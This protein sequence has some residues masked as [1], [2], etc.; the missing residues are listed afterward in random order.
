MNSTDITLQQILL[1]TK[2]KP[3]PQGAG[4]KGHCPAHKDKSPSLSIDQAADGTILLTCHA[5]CSNKAVCVGLN[6]TQADLFPPKLTQGNQA[7]PKYNLD[8]VY[9]YKDESGNLLF[10]AVRRRLANA[11][12]CPNASPKDFKQRQPD[13]N[14]GWIWNLKGVRR[15][16]YRLTELIAAIAANPDITVFIVEGEKD[17]D[18]LRSL[19]LTAT[20]N[21]GGAG[22]WRDEYSDFLVGREVVILP[23]ND[24]AGQNHAQAVA[25]SLHGKAKKIQILDLPKLNP[26]GD[27]SDW[28]DGGGDEDQLCQMSLAAP[29]WTPT[30]QGQQPNPPAQPA[31]KRKIDP[32]DLAQN[33][34]DFFHDP[35]GRQYAS[36]KINAHIETR[37]VDSKGF[38]LWLRG[39]FFKDTGAPL[40]GELLAETVATLQ[41]IAQF[42]SGEKRVHLRV[43]EHGGNIYVDLCDA[44]WRVVEITPNGYQVI[45]PT[46]APVVFTRRGGMSALPEPV[47]GGALA[48]LRDFINCAE[49]QDDYSWALIAGWL[50]MCFHPRG[51][52]PILSIGGEQGSGKSTSCRML[53]RLIDPNAGD[54][55]GVPKDERD[56]M[57]AAN[58]CWLLGYDNLSGATQETSDRLC[59]IST[60]A[61]FGTRTLHTNDEETIFAAR[62]P[63]LVNGIADIHYPDFLDR[64]VSVYLRRI[65]DDQRRDEKTIWAEFMNDKPRILGAL[66]SGVSHALK[67]HQSVKLDHKPRM[68]DFAIWASAAEEGMGLAGGAFITAYEGNREAAH[69]VALDTS[70][71][72]EIR[73]FVESLTDP[74]WQGRAKELLDALNLML[75]GKGIDPLTKW[76][77]PKAANKLT[78]ALRRIG[79]N[80]R[81]VGIEVNCDRS[82]KGSKITIKRTK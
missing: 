21:P 50:V 31:T 10:Q 30:P 17:V 42:Q 6:I 40:H 72:I 75:K 32:I 15:V 63:I 34:A 26:K 37:P 44:Q 71:A 66:L 18:K 9:D 19:G 81:S 55:R 49:P 41:S 1:K 24:Q 77:W 54:L 65:E 67:N 56:L 20:C 46:K 27:V 48:E 4:W 38:K 22:K 23:D 62:R 39:E 12:Q 35:E 8:K 13:G 76:N 57:I 68:A 11:A 53:Q 69:E 61:G 60:G 70:P 79:P 51:P 82:K 59:R 36:I 73:E 7:K 5:K 43:A 16:P 78:E 74:E 58:N 45:E 25:A 47:Q 52:Y 29:E 64:N 80:L 33:K 14:G 28:L 3:N 2:A